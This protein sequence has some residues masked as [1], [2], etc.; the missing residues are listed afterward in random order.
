MNEEVIV[1]GRTQGDFLPIIA[2]SIEKKEIRQIPDLFRAAIAYT[3]DVDK[4]IITLLSM[5]DID[6]NHTYKKCTL[7]DYTFKIGEGMGMELII[8]QAQ[9]ETEYQSICNAV[10]LNLKDIH[11]KN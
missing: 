5:R 7:R 9:I 3:L 2:L 8:I 6:T 4:D 11:T 1:R 10:Y